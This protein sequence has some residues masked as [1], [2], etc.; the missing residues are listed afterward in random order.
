VC[1]YAGR[2]AACSCCRRA[3]ATRRFFRGGNG[4]WSRW[5]GHGRRY[6]S[7]QYS[8][9]GRCHLR[10]WCWRC[11]DL[12]SWRRSRC[13]CRCHDRHGR[14]RSHRWWSLH[15]HIHGGIHDIDFRVQ[16]RYGCR[17]GHG[18]TPNA[19]R[20][21]QGLGDFSHWGGFRSRW[22]CHRYWHRHRDGWW[23]RYRDRH[24][25]GLW[26]GFGFRFR[27]RWRSLSALGDGCAR[28]RRWRGQRHRR[29]GGFG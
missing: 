27:L 12:G 25:H 3:A 26:L 7:G 15:L 5:Q 20:F 22:W 4:R 19:R 23:G 11:H 29:C 17:Q 1:A 13:R 8:G 2:R 24:G 14:G 16:D 9:C 18:F 28:C 6:R 21:R 10:R